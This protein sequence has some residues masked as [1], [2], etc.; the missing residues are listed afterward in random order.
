MRILPDPLCFE[1]D[2]G[3]IEKSHLKHK[4]TFKEA[5]EV[6]INKPRF[7]FE[8]RKHSTKEIRYGMFGTTNL[9]RKLSVVFTVRIEK[10]RIIT[11]RDMSKKERGAYEKIKE[12]S[13]I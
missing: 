7:L 3:N 4:V 2:E 5:E 12:N 10:V 9:G 13:S 11:A 1:W 8:D 6:F